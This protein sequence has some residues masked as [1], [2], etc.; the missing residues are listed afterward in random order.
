MIHHLIIS[1]ILW[2]RISSYCDA[3]ILTFQVQRELNGWGL[4]FAN[5]LVQCQTNCIADTIQIVSG[6]RT[7]AI[8]NNDWTRD[9]DSKFLSFFKIFFL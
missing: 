3:M 4:S 8:R 5:E 9:L 2:K 7:F 1:S 6:S